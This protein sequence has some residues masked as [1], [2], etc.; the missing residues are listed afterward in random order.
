MVGERIR[1][2]RTA[3][4][5]KQ[6]H[7]AREAGISQSTLSRIERGETEPS[8][9][10]VGHLIRILGCTYEDLAM[11]RTGNTASALQLH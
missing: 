7:V 10:V 5:L 3:K 9:T 4:A 11:E 8:F 6:D 1:S 2:I